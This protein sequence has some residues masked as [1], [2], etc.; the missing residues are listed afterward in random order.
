M[1]TSPGSSDEQTPREETARRDLVTT[2]T[3]SWAR[4]IAWI[5][6]LLGS[7]AYLVF[8]AVSVVSYRY[9]PFLQ[10]TLREVEERGFF[11]VW[12]E[13]VANLPSASP[14]WIIDGAFVISL[15]VVLAGAG[16]GAWLLLV[17]S[18]DEASHGQ[19]PISRHQ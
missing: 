1:S 8:G 14:Q 15:A 6:V 16:Y 12:S 11:E 5:V 13:Q 7:V 18:G 19:R 4:R 3:G 10:Q 17:A 2:L 9:S